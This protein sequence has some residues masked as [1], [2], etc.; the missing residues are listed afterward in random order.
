[1]LVRSHAL[2]AKHAVPVMRAQGGGNIVNI[3]SIHALATTPNYAT[4]EAGKAA[5]VHL[6]R[7]LAR[8]LGP[9]G[10]RVN[11]ICPGY[12]KTEKLAAD[13]AQR[14]GREEFLNRIHPVRRVGTPRD[15]A[16]AALFLASPAAGFITGHPIVVD[17][18]LMLEMGLSLAG[19][20]WDES[21][22]G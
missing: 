22:S 6:T 18:G 14:P 17:G 7:Q 2:G 11:C 21:R 5:V 16:E 9:D 12:I 10:I 20:I 15:I 8:D 19:R 3:A 4:Y 1:V 13:L